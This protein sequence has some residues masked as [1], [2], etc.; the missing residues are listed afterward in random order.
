MHK[1]LCFVYCSKAV[2]HGLPIHCFDV[3]N[4]ADLNLSSTLYD[5][6]FRMRTVDCGT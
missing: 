2:V 4:E 3:R 5:V 6:F 1:D